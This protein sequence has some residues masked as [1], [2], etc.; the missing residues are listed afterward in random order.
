MRLLVGFS[1][2]FVGILFIF[3]GLIKL[4]DPMGF[5]FKLQDYFD[6]TVLNLEFLVPYAL[7]LAIV[8]V[9]FEVL[10]GVLLLLGLWRKFTVWS[11]LLMIIFF[12]FLT[13]YSAYF[14][15]VTDCGCF[16]D[17]IPLT[18][19]QSFYKDIIL[20]VFI[21]ILFVGRKHIQPILKRSAGQF[22]V[23][24]SF[25][26]SLGIVYYVLENLPI[27]DF[28]AYKIGV[29]IPEGMSYPDDAEQDVYDY[30]WWFNV[31]GEETKFITQGSYPEVDGEFLRVDTE[32]ISQGYIPPIHDFAIERDGEDYTD[33]Y[34]TKANQ[35]LIIAYNI[36]LGMDKAWEET[37]A[38]TEK[39]KKKGFDVIA[40]SATAEDE[41]A[42]LKSRLDLPYEFFFCDETALKTVIRSIPGIVVLHEGT[43]VEKQ[44]WTNISKLKLEVKN[45]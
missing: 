9:I 6:P 13:F 29:N 40:V 42:A 23:F 45:E 3:S 39:A 27:I 10:V 43:I 38:L 18:P 4:N 32:L 19:W 44:H 35:I 37:K 2:I 36:H 7:P 31:D 22:V 41:V 11:L 28:R 15:K 33:E 5:A 16:G 25:V 12:T 24:V 26:I 30:H 21:L 17:A 1:R 34:M 14:D 20:L 8:I